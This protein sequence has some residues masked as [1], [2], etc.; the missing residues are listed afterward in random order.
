MSREPRWFSEMRARA[1]ARFRPTTPEQQATPTRGEVQ[2]ELEGLARLAQTAEATARE[3]E[4]L[5]VACERR[6][7]AC[8][9]RLRDVRELHRLA[10]IA[11]VA[12]AKRLRDRVAEIRS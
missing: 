11:E 9:G 1:R 5:L 12:S 10:K 7:T 2:T 8:E 3:A 4:G 6:Q